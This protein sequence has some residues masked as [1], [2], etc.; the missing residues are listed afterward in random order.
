MKFRAW[1]KKAKY[2][3]QFSSLYQFFLEYDLQNWTN[4]QMCSGLK[5]KNGKDIYDGDCL[6]SPDG[7]LIVFFEGGC[8]WVGNEGTTCPLYVY[9]EDSKI[10]N[11]QFCA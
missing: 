11:N 5:D 4:L 3:E 9:N 8:F 6:D 1:D 10:M 7:E 2:S